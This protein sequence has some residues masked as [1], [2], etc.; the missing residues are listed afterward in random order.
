MLLQAIMQAP[1]CRSEPATAG[2]LPSATP[3][4]PLPV[5]VHDGEMLRRQFYFALAVHERA[6]QIR[7]VARRAAVEKERLLRSA[8]RGNGQLFGCEAIMN[9]YVILLHQKSARSIEQS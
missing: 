2:Y 4:R 7:T 1:A 3:S 6:T 8:R 5:Q 9:C